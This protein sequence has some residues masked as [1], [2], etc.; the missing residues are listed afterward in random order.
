MKK[1]DTGNLFSI[2][3]ANDDDVFK[4]HGV[5]DYSN[6][7]IILFGRVVRGVE[8]FYIIDMLYISR[9]GE[10]YLEVQDEIKLM[11]FLDLM[12]HFERL[13]DL[14]SDTV[15]TIEDQLGITAI[16][17]ALQQMI[18]F[19]LE[20]EYYEQCAILKSYLDLFSLKKLV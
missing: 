7:P 5:L 6:S 19:F 8:N 16:D 17:Y 18:D 9:F 15:S 12:K 14:T 10:R 1:L 2:F 11:Y 13:K 20:L 3:S 4:E